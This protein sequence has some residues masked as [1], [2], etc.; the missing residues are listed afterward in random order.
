MTIVIR[1]FDKIKNFKYIVFME[2]FII[3]INIFC[4][5]IIFTNSLLVFLFGTKVASAKFHSLFYFSL[6]SEVLF[7]ILVEIFD[8]TIFNYLA[9]YFNLFLPIF[10]LIFILVALYEKFKPIFLILFFIPIFFVFLFLNEQGIIFIV[11]HFIFWTFNV[12]FSI[13]I[14]KK[15][16]KLEKHNEVKHINLMIVT[17][18]FLSV[19]PF[20]ILNFIFII[21][22]KRNSLSGDI[23]PPF[24][25]FVSILD[26]Y[27]I[28][29]NDLLKLNHS[30]YHS[31]SFLKKSAN[32][33]KRNI[34]EKM[35]AS[36]VHEMKN[37]LTSIKSLNGRLKDKFDKMSKDEIINYLE[38][39][40][41]EIDR[42][43]DIS[44]NFLKSCRKD[45]GKVEKLN[46][47]DEINIIK[48]LIRFDFENKFIKLYI[49]VEPDLIIY[50]NSY[51]FR[52][53]ILNIV[54]NAVE[55]NAK[56][57]RIYNNMENNYINIV[58]ENDGNQISKDFEEKIFQPFF[59]TKYDGNGMGLSIC[60]EILNNN[61]SDIVLIKSIENQTIFKLSF[62]I[63]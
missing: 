17:L 41:S 45:D 1:F 46:I 59:T 33:E 31:L 5:G 58:I 49:D 24:I 19:F 60:K 52:Q 3:Y 44:S 37:P 14:S 8:F 43:N 42:I 63:K 26:I 7:S 23:V 15:I 61:M 29:E 11:Y 32:V 21:L 53:V 55:A 50:F 39:I 2:K 4:A 51:E 36:I 28:Y 40:D 30:Y 62:F 20:I 12:F 13:F 38:I 27:F 10:Y 6:F 56:N 25:A 35:T 47:L 57:I 18:I 9:N 48:N 34:I 22:L 16:R 54:Y